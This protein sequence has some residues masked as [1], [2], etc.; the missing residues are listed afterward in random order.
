MAT[1]DIKYTLN[2]QL[3]DNTVTV[4]DKT[5]RIL[6]LVSAGSVDK[7]RIISEIMALNP[8]LERETV[9]AVVNLEQRVIQKMV[10]T[11]FHVNMGL[12][13]AVAQFTGVVENKTW[14]PEKNTVYASFTQGADMREAI[15]QTGINI[16]G[17]KSATMYVAGTT[18]VSTRATNA[19]ATAGRNFT[20][21]GSM[22]KVVGADPSVGITLKSSK[23]TVTKITEDMWG[24]NDPSKL[25]FIIP[26]GL[27][28]GE[29]TLTITTQYGGNSKTMLKTPKSIS[30]TIYIG[31]APAGG[32]DGGNTGGDGGDGNPDE[33]P[34]G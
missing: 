26:A 18:D 8:G 28:D 3:A 2:T 25:M 5:D 20:V 17:E 4:D 29:Y 13:Q 21:T 6:T 10:L 31:Q 12:Y 7:Q 27:A 16:I 30:Q 33:N 1:N 24:T 14:N 15:R 32:G 23:G 9:E 34:L 22:L 19:S 11:G